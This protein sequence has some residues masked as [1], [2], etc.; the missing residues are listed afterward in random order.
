MQK[1]LHSLFEVVTSYLQALLEGA[2]YM[3]RTP[4]RNKK[5]KILP[6]LRSKMSPEITSNDHRLL[7]FH[8]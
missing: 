5:I 2:G 8:V 3:L 4:E 7:I 1:T 6:S